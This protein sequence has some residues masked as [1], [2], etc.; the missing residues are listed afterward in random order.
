VGYWGPCPQS[1]TLKNFRRINTDNVQKNNAIFAQFLVTFGEF[2][3]L[4]SRNFPEES[5]YR[6]QNAETI[7]NKFQFHTN[8]RFG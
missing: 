8:F 5:K 1:T 3:S 6:S 2:L 4:F 7:A